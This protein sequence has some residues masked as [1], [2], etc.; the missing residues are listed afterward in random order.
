MQKTDTTKD[1]LKQVF[2]VFKDSKAAHAEAMRR[3][4]KI[5]GKQN[6]K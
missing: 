6:S 2:Q 1:Q 4:D 3:L 5:I